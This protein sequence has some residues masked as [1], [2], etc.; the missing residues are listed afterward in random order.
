M[1]SLCSGRPSAYREQLELRKRKEKKTRAFAVKIVDPVRREGE[2][3]RRVDAIG[4]FPYGPL[5]PHPTA[6]QHPTPSLFIA[7]FICR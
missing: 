6:Q 4:A 7:V 1:L 5:A 2:E 3:Q